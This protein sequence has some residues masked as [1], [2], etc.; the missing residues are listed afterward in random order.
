MK[1]LFHNKEDRMKRSVSL[2]AVAALLVCSSAFAAE[3]KTYPGPQEAAPN[4]YKMLL[5]NDKVRISEITFKPGD[6]AAMHT[7]P[8]PHAVYIIEGG[9]LTI[10]KLDGTSTVVDAKPGDVMWMGVETHEGVNTG[11][12]TLRGTVTEIK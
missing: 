9:Q 12:T 8:Y 1:P 10:T 3:T 2:F 6:K 11:T 4:I 7:H 5:D